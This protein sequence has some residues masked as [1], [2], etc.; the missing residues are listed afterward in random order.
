ML[1]FWRLSRLDLNEDVSRLDELAEIIA[2]LDGS[3]FEW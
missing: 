2:P 1:L 3:Q